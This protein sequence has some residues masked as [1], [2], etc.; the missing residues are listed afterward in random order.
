MKVVFIDVEQGDSSLVMLSDGTAILVDCNFYSDQDYKR[1]HQLLKNEG[2]NPDILDVLIITHPHEDHIRGIGRLYEEFEVKAIYESGHRLYVSDEEKSK[3]Y[4]DMIGVIS[5]LKQKG[6]VHRRLKAY[7]EMTFGNA[8]LR[9][10]SPT[11]AFLSEEKPTERDIHDQCLVFQ[12]EEF[13]RKVLF[14]GDSSMEAWRDKIVPFYS[15]ENGKPNLLQSTILHASHHGSNTFFYSNAAGNGDPYLDGIKKVAPT[16]SVVSAGV[17]NRHGHPDRQALEYYK[18]H[19]KCEKH[20]YQ[21]KHQGSIIFSVKKNGDYDVF[22][23]DFLKRAKFSGMNGASVSISATPSNLGHYAKGVEIR[24][25]ATYRNIPD[26]QTIGSIKWSV[27]NNSQGGFDNHDFYVGQES[28]S[29]QY[30]NRTAYNGDHLL[31]CEV[32][33]KAG[34]TICTDTMVVKVR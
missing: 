15:D 9:V 21:T 19:S 1:V 17:A 8:K 7:E 20:V 28:T 14:T 22:T 30:V 25:K 5:K 18:K 12:I 23:E 3:H 27:Q 26:G 24:F 32:K 13:G 10:F 6:A 11:K 29:S 16:I 4:K 31:L 34:K 2:L 33:N